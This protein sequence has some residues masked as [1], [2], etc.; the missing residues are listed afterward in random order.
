MRWI[1][2][3]LLA[4]ATV[5]CE[6]SDPGSDASSESTDQ[7]LVEMPPAD[8]SPKKYKLTPF[9]PSKEFPDAK[10]AS[11]EYDGANWKFEITGDYELGVQTPDAGS[12]GCANSAKGQHIHLIADVDPYVAQYVPEFEHQIADGRRCVLAF[13]SRS[14][15]ESIKTEGAYLAKLYR[16]SDGVVQKTD[17]IDWP[18]VFYSRPKGIYEGK[19]T[20]KVMLDYY[21]INHDPEKHWVKADINGEVHQLMDWQPYYIEGLPAGENKI[22]LTLMEGLDPAY[23]SYNPVSRTF[24]LNPE[25]PVN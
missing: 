1:L 17:S 2:L 23:T 6:S 25:P 13:L 22:T 4:I 19:D 21:L 9:T 8:D 10:L 5:A 11:M 18:M 3:S 14:Y 16:I 24:K 15:H 7:A 20:E 12:K